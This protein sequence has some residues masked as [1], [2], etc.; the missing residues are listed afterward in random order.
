MPPITP[1][2]PLQSNDSF[3]QRLQAGIKAFAQQLV[4]NPV[5]S[6]NVVTATFNATFTDTLVTHNLGNGTNVAYLHGSSTQ[7][8]ALTFIS[9]KK[10][11]TPAQTIYLQVTTEGS[12]DTTI[13][14]F[15]PPLQITLYFF[16]AVT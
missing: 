16:N 15:D 2:V 7:N 9:T 12:A 6:G 1:F 11:P 14:K 8:G 10:S 13:E 4:G 3:M 5:L